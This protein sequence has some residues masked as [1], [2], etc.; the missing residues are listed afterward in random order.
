MKRLFW[1][2]VGIAV[3]AVVVRQLSRTA[4]AYS[5]SG[6]A[7]SARNSAAG[8]WESVQDFVADVREG[9]AEREEEIQAAFA[10][11]VSLSDV[12]EGEFYDE[13]EY[14][15]LNDDEDFGSWDDGGRDSGSKDSG[16]KDYG[17]KDQGN[18]AGVR[19]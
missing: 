3:G 6:L 11:G 16:S 10:Q 18:G 7:G 14:G 5:P 2:G 8:L 1:L 13:L 12:D 9:M 15:V 17:S 19:R 4:H